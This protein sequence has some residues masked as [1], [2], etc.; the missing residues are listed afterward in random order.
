MRRIAAFCLSSLACLAT[1]SAQTPV[2]PEE[3]GGFSFEITTDLENDAPFYFVQIFHQGDL[4]QGGVFDLTKRPISLAKM[5]DRRA[6]E[7]AATATIDPT[8]PSPKIT[9]TLPD[10]TALWGNFAPTDL[11]LPRKVVPLFRDVPCDGKH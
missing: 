1:G 11:D 9:V 10:E 6:T 8:A 7:V 3:A 4:Y 2:C 5:V